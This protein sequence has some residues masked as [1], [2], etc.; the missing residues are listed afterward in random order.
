MAGRNKLSD[1]ERERRQLEKE[2]LLSGRKKYNRNKNEPNLNNQNVAGENN[3]TNQNTNE[4]VNT[5][6]GENNTP[7]AI[8]ETVK[9][10]TPIATV[11]ETVNPDNKSG[12]SD[13]ANFQPNKNWKPLGGDKIQRDY[14]TPKIDQNLLNTPIPEVNIDAST[15]NNVNSQD[16]LNKPITDANNNP[17]AKQ[18]PAPPPTPIVS[19][20]NTLTDKEK[21][22]AAAQTADMILGVYDKLHYFGRA[23]IKVDDEE[24]IEKHNDD[25]IDMHAATVESDDDPEKEVTIQDFWKDFNKQV[26]ERFIVSEQF[27]AAV[28]PPMERL[29]MKYGLG[30]SDGMFLAYKFGEDA[31]TKIAM[32][33]GFKK[34]VNHM[35]E[36][37]E[38]RHAKFKAEV[39]KE[40]QRRIAKENK[41][42]AKDNKEKKAE[43]VATTTANPEE[44]AGEKK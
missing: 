43:I 14:S 13:N 30:A 44:T 16:L 28:R 42:T 8:T 18:Q 41:E 29:C 32:V 31:A 5:N 39:E 33:V 26:D 19:D 3:D 4:A 7:A 23:A 37:F 24:I 10:E 15:T 40:V 25:V 1:D 20:W 2:E 9:T 11:T 12:L 38:K 27:K 22:D 21:Q 36:M 35:N 17:G 6:T 34:T